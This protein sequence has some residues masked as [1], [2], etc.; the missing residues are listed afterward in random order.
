MHPPAGCHFHTRCPRK[1]E[2]CERTIPELTE[3]GNGHYVACHLL[4]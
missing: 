4:N 2:V 3:I 1:K